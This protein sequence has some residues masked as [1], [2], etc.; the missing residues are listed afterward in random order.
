MFDNI[1]TV[2]LFR[3]DSKK[4]IVPFNETAEDRSRAPKFIIKTAACTVL[5]AALMLTCSSNLPLLQ[6]K[7]TGGT[8]AKSSAASSK[9][10]H[11]FELIV[12]AAQT[13]DSSS[14]AKETKG[15][16]LV[17]DEN[18]TLP[19]GKIDYKTS[20]DSDGNTCFIYGCG[21]NG[22]FNFDYE[23]SGISSVT[24]TAAKLDLEYSTPEYDKKYN[25]EIT[26]P[27]C[28]FNIPTVKLSESY[29][30]LS[31]LIDIWASGELDSYKTKYFTGK[32]TDLCDY[33][34]TYDSIPNSNDTSVSIY[35]KT[36]PAD[37]NPYLESKSVTEDNNNKYEYIRWNYFDTITKIFDNYA[38]LKIPKV[39]Y[40]T[41]PGDTITVTAKF[42]DGTTLTKHIVLSFDKDGNL[43]A[44]LID[45]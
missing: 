7:L 1:R 44:K 15:T 22:S 23:G 33:N 13:P 20:S 28:V 9:I 10:S 26:A 34:I 5:A 21:E 45:N 27:V 36:T 32:D 31:S 43:C 12:G 29:N 24:Y 3:A 18:K 30:K 39:D 17:P 37:L 4:I 40:T 41:L 8:T 19:T 14:S 35:S 16:V 42:T 25:D 11:D 38:E 6:S 2:K